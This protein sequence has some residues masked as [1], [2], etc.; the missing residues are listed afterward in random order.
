MV[1]KKTKSVAHK[2][3]A[4]KAK[5]HVH[6]K[7]EKLSLDQIIPKDNNAWLSAGIFILIGLIIGALVVGTMVPAQQQVETCDVNVVNVAALSAKVGDYLN[8]NLVLDDTV[9]ASIIDS[10]ELESGLYELS[11]EVVQEGQVVGEGQI[12][13]TENSI[14]L[15]TKFNL[16]EP[17]EVDNPTKPTTGA[18]VQSAEVAEAELF[19]WGYCP[20]GIATLDKYAE[21]AAA[22]SAVAN[23]KVVPFHDG[24]GAF[25]TREN[26]IMLAIQELES[27]KTWSYMVDFY[28][29]VYPVCSQQ[30]TV[31]CTNIESR[32]LME[33]VGIDADAVMALADEK[34]DKMFAAAQN[35]AAEL[36]IGTSPTLVVNNTS[37][38]SQFVRAPDGIKTLICSGFID[39][40][41]VCSVELGSDVSAA[42]GSC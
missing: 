4:H 29:D 9:V 35:R 20:G 31:E 22:L 14:I 15:G 1:K 40:P 39:Q 26:K 34:G 32:K 18:E 7:E 23:V 33:K 19:V 8:N 27:E 21:A 36:G 5:T 37:L 17:I 10:I 16:N 2:K 25:E 13:A 6:K 11:F 42:T 41:E 28:E 12:Y 38:G 24:H 30:Q 3:T